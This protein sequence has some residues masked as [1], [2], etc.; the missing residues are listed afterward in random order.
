[1]DQR[2][3]DASLKEV[4]ATVQGK[5]KN[6]LWTKD[7]LGNKVFVGDKVILSESCYSGLTTGLVSRVTPK[8]VRI[9]NKGFY[10][11]KAFCKINWYGQ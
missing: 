5:T 6:P 4:F 8:G 10:L 9:E 11:S 3:K 7:F 1:M 2:I